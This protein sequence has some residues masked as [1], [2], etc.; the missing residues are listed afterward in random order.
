[1][2]SYPVEISDTEGIVNAV[3]YL[4]SGPAG[5][6]Q[7]FQGFSAYLP[8]YIRPSSLLPWSLPIDTTLDPSLYLDI[9]ISDAAP[10]GSNPSALIILTFVTPFA[11]P[12]FQDGDKL[13]IANV[14]DDGGGDPP[15]SYNDNG[16]TV[17]SCT[18]TDVTLTFDNTVYEWANY[19]SGGTVG[20]N[21]LNFANSTDCNARVTVQGPTTQVFVSAQ[22]NLTWE[23]ICATA[24][25]YNVK[26]SI[27]R[28][29]GFPTQTPGDNEFLF[30]G[31]VLVSQ[32]TFAK[33][34]TAGTG[35][36]TLE[37]IFTTVLDGPNLDFGFYWYI[38]DV[39]FSV[40]GSMSEETDSRD[41]D[42]SGVIDPITSSF[43]SISPTTV[44]GTGSGLVVDVQLDS[45]DVSTYNT[46]T[47][48]TI[49]VI[50]GGSDYRIG[51]ILKIP[52]TDL[53]GASP[54]NDMNLVI[55]FVIEPF[56][57]TIGPV[58]TGLRSLT[59]QVIKQ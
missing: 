15:Y 58:I 11:T 43:T 32:K 53:G 27:K 12:P 38:M 52:G 57:I 20:R 42:L 45:A 7:N 4:M 49:D 24:N 16:Y 10:V 50:S 46:F 3:N 13:D 30:A 19:I 51:D 2:S 47:N 28:L 21:Y 41:F 56:D 14:V 34:A 44:T 35:T 48:T 23:Y 9:P 8:A 17:Y 39:E 22:L 40:P 36:E 1:M 5:L 6:G 37:A 55:N 26:V 31:E 33:A 54:A 18:T 29:K 59:A 25:T